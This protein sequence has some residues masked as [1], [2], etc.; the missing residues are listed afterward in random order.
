MIAKVTTA[1]ATLIDSNTIFEVADSCAAIRINNA[2]YHEGIA[3]SASASK[4][5]PDII[6][7]WTNPSFSED[8]NIAVDDTGIY[9]YIPA[10]KTYVTVNTGLTFKTYK[11][12]WASGNRLLVASW[13]NE[14]PANTRSFEIKAFV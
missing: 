5:T 13:G 8:L 2:I 14:E 6:P 3:A 10:T 1:K 9:K 12:V 4:Y 7:S 11:R